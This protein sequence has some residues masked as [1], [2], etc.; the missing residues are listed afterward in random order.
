MYLKCLN[1]DYFTVGLKK[2]FLEEE[3]KRLEHQ[4]KQVLGE[5]EMMKCQI[6]TTEEQNE[7]LQTELNRFRTRLTK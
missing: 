5:M 6:T 4:L 1:I 2:D 3:V 7:N